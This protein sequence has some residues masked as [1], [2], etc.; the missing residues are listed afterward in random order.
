MISFILRVSLKLPFC[1]LL[2]LQI[3][4]P[5]LALF[6]SAPD[7]YR[8]VSFDRI[9]GPEYDSSQ[10]FWILCHVGCNGSWRIYNIKRSNRNYNICMFLNSVWSINFSDF[11]SYFRADR[12]P[13]WWIWGFWISPLMYAQ[14]S[15]SVNEFL[16]H[17]WDKV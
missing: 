11:I 9:P 10:Y 17:S 3:F 2:D 5:V 15:A 4:A 13:V 7:V 16:G 6:F 14:N 12:I 1:V 8:S